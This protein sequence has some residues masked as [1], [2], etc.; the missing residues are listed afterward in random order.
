MNKLKH[1]AWLSIT[2]DWKTRIVLLGFF[3]FLGS[4]SLLYRQREIVLPV[5]EIR[6]ETEEVNQIF[7]LIP[8]SHWEGELAEE[9]QQRLGNN[10]FYL[11]LQ[12]YIYDHQEGNNI[13][14]MEEISDYLEYGQ[15]IQENNLFLH[16]AT[17]F[18]SHD[19]LV[20]EYLPP[21]EDVEAELR[22]YQAMTDRDMLFERNPLA[23]SQVLM[24]QAETIAGISLFIFVAILAADHFTRDQMKNWSVTQGLPIA[25]KAQWH[26]RTTILWG[27]FW[28]VGLLGVITSYVISLFFET[29]G[30]LAYP[31]GLYFR[32]AMHYISL[33]Q[34]VLLLIGISMLFS[35]VLLLLTTGLSWFIRNIYL[36]ILLVVG[37][38]F[39]PAIWNGI[40]PF[41]SWQPTL[42]MNPLQI[43]QGRSAQIYGLTGLEFWK[44]P[45]IL[46][47]L[48]IILEVVFSNIFSLIP[49][50]TLGLKRRESK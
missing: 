31:V 14:G 6:H 44:I 32:G 33:W 11:G 47:I 16:D 4:F 12:R 36:T 23:S 25:W 10:S 5:Q 1:W 42:Y 8:D 46:F 26:L 24:A 34:Y 13:P 29:T 41:S 3:L 21:R 37:I 35:Y 43:I 19:I 45:I 40:Q 7:R 20:E 2:R 18:E 28:L 38:F 22:F 17:E 50:K 27:L 48:W 15:R 49:T 30:E 9:V 39:L